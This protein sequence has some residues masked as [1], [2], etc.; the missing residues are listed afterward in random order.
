MSDIIKLEVIQKNFISKIYELRE[1]NYWEKLEKI[2]LQSLQRRRE[3]YCLIHMWKIVNNIAP[4]D[5][6]FEFY[7]NARRGIK[8]SLKPILQVGSKYQT[9]RDNSFAHVG[10]KLWNILPKNVSEETSLSGFK[11]SLAKF[12]EKYPDKPPVPGLA[13]INNNSIL[14]YPRFL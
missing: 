9:L 11:I 5:L 2:N 1:L 14:N 6:C 13:Y 12:L 10:P 4:N 8:A 7:S 3:R